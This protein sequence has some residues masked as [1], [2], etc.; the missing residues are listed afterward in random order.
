[1]SNHMPAPERIREIGEYFI[2]LYEDEN[3]VDMEEQEILKDFRNCTTIACHAG[4]YAM[5]LSGHESAFFTP[6]DLDSSALRKGGDWVDYKMGI[7]LILTDLGFIDE[8][9]FDK[10]AEIEEIW[11]NP[12]GPKMFNSNGALAFGFQ[13][14]AHITLKII[15]HHWLNVAKRQHDYNIAQIEADNLQ[16]T[17]G[18]KHEKI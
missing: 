11:G 16:T 1:M 14:G 5:K 15:G 9:D 6:R 2:A 8:Y 17:N 3:I 18:G 10:W 4:W 12:Y 7:D 13:Q